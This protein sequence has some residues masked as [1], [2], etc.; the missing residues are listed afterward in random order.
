MRVAWSWF[1][2]AVPVL[3]MGCAESA[4]TGVTPGVEFAQSPTVLASP[5][6]PSPAATATPSRTVNRA[7]TPQP[8]GTF[9]VACGDI[10]AP[11]D[12]QHRL[13]A[14]C[15]PSDLVAL[16]AEMSSGGVQL[17]REEAAAA[18]RGLF[19]AAQRDSFTIF[20]ASAYRSYATQV[21]VYGSNV[22]RNGQAAADRVSARPGHSEHQLGTTTDVTSASAG[23][24]LAGFRGTP[25]AAWLAENAW[26]FGFI[27]SY[28]EGTEHITGYAYEPW[29]IRWIGTEEAARVRESGLTLHEW[30]LR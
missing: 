24:G 13:P 6:A 2:V 20:A 23:F 21:A 17:M 5:T 4:R 15:V 26:K 22:A 9:V 27:V 1:A 8:D 10:L 12:K 29:H 11:L 30:L 16:P 14:D 25:E 18:F 28:T 3:V 7:G 19:A